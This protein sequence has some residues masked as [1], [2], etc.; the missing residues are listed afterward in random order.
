MDIEFTPE[1]Q[2][3]EEEIFAYLRDNQPPGIEEELI[4]NIEGEGP[5]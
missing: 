1:Q 5:L 4:N 3:F 2:K